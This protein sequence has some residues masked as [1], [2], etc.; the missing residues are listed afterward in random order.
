MRLLVVPTAG[1][2]LLGGVLWLSGIPLS[3]AGDSGDEGVQ[4]VSEGTG[5]ACLG[6]PLVALS[7]LARI[8]RDYGQPLTAGQVVLSGALGPMRDAPPGC[9]VRAEISTLGDVTAEFSTLTE[10]A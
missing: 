5:A 9:T 6:D 7:W 1:A 4:L 2:A 8:A 3:N 10:D